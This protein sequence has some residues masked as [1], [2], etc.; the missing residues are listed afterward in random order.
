MTD[1]QQ[2]QDTRLARIEDK[3]DKNAA[4]EIAVAVGGGVQFR[5]MLEVMEFAKLM[6]L[7]GA[8]VTPHC[9]GNPGVCLAVI[10]QA[11]EWGMSPFAVANKSYMVA[12]KGVE[13]L[14]FE[15]Q[16]IHAVIEARAPIVGRLAVYYEGEG[17]ARICI[18]QGQ[19][20]GETLPREWR[21]PP[22]GKR[23][24]GRNEHG[25]IKGSP[26]W[27]TKP[28]LQQFYDA[29]RDWCRVYCPDVLLGIY[30]PDELEE[31][32]VGDHAKEV[33]ASPNLMERLPGRMDGDGFQPDV[34]E[35]GLAMARK[36]PSRK[37]KAKEATQEPVTIIPPTGDA[38]PQPAGYAGERIP[39]TAGE[40]E[41]YATWWISQ[42]ATRA[43]A[44][45]RWDAER[46]LRDTLQVPIGVR[47]QLSRQIEGVM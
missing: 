33:V 42:E 18:V 20:K 11:I 46:D 29:S 16:L 3:L 7:A 31:L 13:R 43:Q 47:N 23:R 1:L 17:D 12:N 44:M 25:Q 21:S 37:R 38:A 35:N 4:G 39:E 27:E 28:D 30:S 5:S 32:P 9:R 22:L 41:V 45:E 24:P 6:S 2:H 34:V 15:S 14:S 8:A 40:Y 19:F 10:M 26:L 36:P